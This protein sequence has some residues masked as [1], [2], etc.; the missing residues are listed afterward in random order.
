MEG[1]RTKRRRL[2]HLFCRYVLYCIVLYC[3]V[4]TLPCFSNLHSP[5]RWP[6]HNTTSRA[7]SQ[8]ISNEWSCVE[9]ELVGTF[10]PLIGH[11]NSNFFAAFCSSNKEYFLSVFCI[12]QRRRKRRHNHANTETKRRNKQTNKQQP[13]SQKR[14]QATDFYKLITNHEPPK[15]RE[16]QVT[17]PSPSV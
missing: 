3:I 5:T 17:S 8:C 4:H 16:Q 1:G 7:E 2:H 9:L 12:R 11:K 6:K 14:W 13:S 15:Q 10:L